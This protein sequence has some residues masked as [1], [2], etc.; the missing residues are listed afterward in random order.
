LTGRTPFIYRAR[1][2]ASHR[3]TVH[4]V[5]KDKRAEGAVTRVVVDV[6]RVVVDVR[7]V[8]QDREMTAVGAARGLIR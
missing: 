3:L 2:M 1:V 7:G 5:V 6:R 4:G 8:N